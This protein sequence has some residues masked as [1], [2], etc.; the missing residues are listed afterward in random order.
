MPVAPSVINTFIFCKVE[1]ASGALQDAKGQ[2]SG[3]RG[4]GQLEAMDVTTEGLQIRTE[5]QKAIDDER[6][7]LYI[8]YEGMIWLHNCMRAD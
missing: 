5:L 1:A 6:C 7:V 8:S 3:A 2:G 4:R